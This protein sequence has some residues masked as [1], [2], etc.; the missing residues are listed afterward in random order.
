MVFRSWLMSLADWGSLETRIDR[1]GP[2]ELDVT[3][4]YAEELARAVADLH[5]HNL[6]HRD[7]KPGNVLFA[8]TRDGGEQLVLGDFGMARALDRSALTLR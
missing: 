7:L 5:A 4:G 8:S 3:L 1:Q 2:F 6:L